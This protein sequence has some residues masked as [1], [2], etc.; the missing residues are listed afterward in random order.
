MCIKSGNATVLKA[1]QLRDILAQL[2]QM[3]PQMFLGKKYSE[4]G[5]TAVQVLKTCA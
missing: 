2:K 3:F 4:D 5:S 1:T